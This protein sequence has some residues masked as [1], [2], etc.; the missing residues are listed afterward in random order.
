M[1][2][3]II[4]TVIGILIN[5]TT[6]ASGR[7]YVIK[8]SHVTSTNSPKGKAA[9]MLAKLVNKRLSGKLRM[10]VYPNSQLYDDNKV[11]DAL[12]LSS[13]KSHGIMAAPSLSKFVKFS[14]IYCLIIS[15]VP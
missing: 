14:K 12:R 3:I 4:L 13:S 5:I 15:L 7:E 1:K 2:R 9:D 8:F 11:L 6:S 10:E